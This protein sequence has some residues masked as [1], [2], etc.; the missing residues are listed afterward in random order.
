MGSHAGKGSAHRCQALPWCPTVEALVAA[1]VGV[2]QALVLTTSQRGPHHDGSLYGITCRDIGVRMRSSSVAASPSAG[3]SRADN[4][5]REPSWVRAV[6]KDP[7][8]TL[9]VPRGIWKGSTMVRILQVS[10]WFL[11]SA[12]VRKALPHRGH[13]VIVRQSNLQ[14]QEA[15]SHGPTLR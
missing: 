11:T 8:R 3:P 6:S 10:I 2:G 14:G 4:E 7:D 1:V 12:L 9:C 15:R 5:S 13:S